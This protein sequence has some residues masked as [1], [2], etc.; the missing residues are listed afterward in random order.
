M[1]LT[2]LW[3]K[4]FRLWAA[5]ILI[6]LQ[7]TTGASA[8]GEYQRSN[9]TVWET[10]LALLNK[11]QPAQAL[12]HLEQLVTRDP[13]NID[14]R[15]ELALTL[16][17]LGQDSRAKHHLSLLKATHLTPG[18]R[19]AVDQLSVQIDGRNKLTGY[20]TFGILPETNVGKLTENEIINIGGIPF[21]LNAVGKPGVSV[22]VNAGVAYN[23]KFTDKLQAKYRLDLSSQLNN[24]KAY[25]DTSLIARAGLAS[26]ARGR[27][28]VESGLILGRRWLAGNPY[29]NTTGAYLAYSKQAGTNGRINFDLNLAQTRHLGKA[30]DNNI[31]YAKLAYTHGISANAQI[32]V[33]VFHQHTNSTDVSVAGQSFGAKISSV[34]AFPGGLVAGL[35]LSQAVDRRD[36][37][38]PV[39]FTEARKDNKTK[40]DLSLH[41]RNFRIGAFAPQLIIGIERNSSN[42]ALVD[43]TNKYMSIG[44]TRKF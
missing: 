38:N 36:G 42:N 29:S 43:Y 18:A 11:R 9:D 24:D 20:F 15:F 8:L 34:Y 32:T 1:R 10:A 16:F 12:P 25:R 5:S 22:K 26:L 4:A 30:P 19:S 3:P 37:F 44:F 27:S 40:L 14:Y 2:H 35:S 7:L 23:Q 13:A 39:F 6:L 31:A 41:H 17:K 28:S 33:S 21:Q